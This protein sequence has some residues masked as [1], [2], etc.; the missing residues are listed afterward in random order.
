MKFKIDEFGKKVITVSI[1]AIIIIFIAQFGENM[2]AGVKRF[3]GIISPVFIGFGIAY[4]LNQPVKYLTDKFKMKQNMSVGIVILLLIIFIVFSS[5]FVLPILAQNIMAL[6][7]TLPS[8]VDSMTKVFEEMNIG[9]SVFKKFIE[10]NANKITETIAAISNFILS[11]MSNMLAYSGKVFMNTFIGI[12]LAIYMLLDKQNIVM[13]AKKIT[14]ILFGKARE[15]KISMLAGKAN[16][17]FAHFI[18]GLILE[19]VF[20][21]VIAF[22]GFYFMKIPYALM[23]SIVI[24]FT[25]M[26]PYIGPFIGL[27]PAV[28]VA[29]MHKPITAI[30][31]IIFI[32][33]LQQIDANI[34]GPKIMGNFIGLKP[35]WIIISIL[36][37]GNLFG[38]L[39]MLL[40]IPTAAFIKI[41]LDEILD[42][43]NKEHYN[44][45]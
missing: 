18:M 15:N 39:G 34:I 26:I 25:N 12:V 38:F 24:F 41:V 22:I 8:S 2:F 21:G 32:T 27:A 44:I 9:G 23:L 42:D 7:K 11:N 35:M 4:L 13:G 16:Y 20:V 45:E 1:A 36:I 3:I 37:G 30:Y 31:V 33:I 40:A 19:A 43:Y 14:A 5:S 10:E 17:V 6:I 29:L 28:M